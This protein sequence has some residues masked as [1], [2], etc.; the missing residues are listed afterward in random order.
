[1]HYTD[2]LSTQALTTRFITPADA[3]AWLEYTSDAM[4]TTYTAVPGKSAAGLA[5]LFV[6]AT[7]ARYRE[8]RYGLQALLS[9]ETGELVG[10]CGLL[11]QQVSG[12]PELEVGYHLLRRFWGR[13]YATQ[14]ARM[15]RDYGFEHVGADSIVSVIDPHNTASQ[16]VALRNGMQLADTAA[17]LNGNKYWLYRITRAQWQQQRG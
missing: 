11:L 9:K 8:G 15:F 1:M 4:A 5:D 7:L 2:Q 14:A 12:R 10:M 6:S 3:A 16:K 13:G 17:V